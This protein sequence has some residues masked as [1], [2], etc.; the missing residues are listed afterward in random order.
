MSSSSTTTKPNAMMPSK[1]KPTT[2]KKRKVIKSEASSIFTKNG[3][4]EVTLIGGTGA[5]MGNQPYV[6]QFT[7][8]RR[9]KYAFPLKDVE[10]TYK[11]GA[12]T[13]EYMKCPPDAKPER[14]T[15]KGSVVGNRLQG[16]R[17]SVSGVSE[18]N[19]V[20]YAS[21]ELHNDYVC[22]EEQFA[23][24][25]RFDDP[26]TEIDGM[27]IGDQSYSDCH[28]SCGKCHDSWGPEKC[29]NCK[30]ETYQTCQY[31]DTM[32][33]D[34]CY[35]QWADDYVCVNCFQQHYIEE[36]KIVKGDPDWDYEDI[37]FMVADH[38]FKYHCPSDKDE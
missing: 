8:S 9:W 3:I 31:C 13:L 29:Y 18:T 24:L 7:C 19:V 35:V 15:Y 26:V 2:S 1:R 14:K 20:L 23:A 17:Y 22:C 21:W 36:H 33:C 5:R 27:A 6:L 37:G 4:Q 16:L 38:K 30:E 11:D 12:Y 34:G 10:F 25:I 28:R 32:M